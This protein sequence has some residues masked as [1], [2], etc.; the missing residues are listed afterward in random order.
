MPDI[1]SDCLNISE[2]FIEEEKEIST[3]DESVTRLTD[4]IKP[5][6]REMFFYELDS[7]CRERDEALQTNDMLK[8][9]LNHSNLSSKLVENNDAKCKHLTGLAWGVFLHTFT[10]LVSFVSNKGMGR[11]G[12]PLREQFL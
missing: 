10:F 4:P 1:S 12:L 7:L 11:E 3:K 6:E 5:S 8:A 9:K 2:G